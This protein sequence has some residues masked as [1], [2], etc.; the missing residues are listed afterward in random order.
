MSAQIHN[1]ERLLASLP[2]IWQ[3]ELTAQ[4][5]ALLADL[6][7]SLVVLDDD[8]TGT[9]TVHSVV[10]LTDWSVERLAEEF[11]RRPAVFYILTNSRSLVPEQAEAL[12]REI[13]TNLREA[14]RKAGRSYRV[15]SRSDSTLRG[16]FPLELGALE[17]TLEQSVDA[18]LL[19]PFFAEGGRLTINQIHY[20]TQGE[21]LVPA[22]ETEFA[23]DAAF[24]YRSSNLREWVEEKSGGE[25]KAS[26]VQVIGLELIRR[27][28]PEAV[29]AALDSL[30]Q[31]SVC[32]VESACNEDLACFSV[33]LLL[34][35]RRG[36]RYLYRTAAS[37]VAQ[38]AGIAPRPLLTREELVAESERGGLF[39]VGSYVPTTTKQVEELRR[40]VELD[41][42]ELPVQELLSERRDELIARCRA[43]LEAGLLAG[44]DQLVMTSRELLR[45]E[46]AKQSLAIGATVSESLCDL[47]RGLKV[48]PR[49]MVA[50]GGITS[51]DLA[52]RGLGVK[53]ATVL[54]QVLPG[55]PVWRLGE[56]SAFPGLS[57]VVFPGNVGGSDA[58]V[59]LAERVSLE[60]G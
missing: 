14:A 27:G 33:G 6:D 20:V 45:G 11:A 60:G 21:R 16:H 40:R 39:V 22:G 36:R 52:T 26:E 30:P 7:Q 15:V 31:G 56:E 57:Y 5:A 18:W 42:L 4:K 35:E 49:W 12:T 1:K 53:R 2:P 9:Q 50:K 46:D 25:I 32:V 19:I 48:R 41:C 59:Q 10:V 44:R 23:R 8:P 24:G 17:P 55:V 38:R 13:G 58:L 29:A 28:G 54:G 43:Q 34:S 47:V 51:S 3:G 37:F